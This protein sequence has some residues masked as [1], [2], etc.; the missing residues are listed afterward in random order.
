MWHWEQSCWNADEALARVET[1]VATGQFKYP[2]WRYP[3]LKPYRGFSGAQRIAGW[4]HVWVARAMGL[5]PSPAICSVC[6]RA[7]QGQYHCEDYSSPL[8]AKPVCRSCHQIIHRR[9]HSRPRWADHL[10]QFGRPRA[11]FMNLCEDDTTEHGRFKSRN[12]R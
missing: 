7:C 11:W 6:L 1:A 9:F 3:M 12:V 5:L 2:Q 4:Q 10:K 8:D